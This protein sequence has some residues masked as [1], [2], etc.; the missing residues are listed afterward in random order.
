MLH[1]PR[2]SWTLILQIREKKPRE[3]MSFVPVQQLVSGKARMDNH[4]S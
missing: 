1:E 2:D 3:D 4:V